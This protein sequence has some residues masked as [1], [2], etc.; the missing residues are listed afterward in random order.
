MPILAGSYQDRGCERLTQCS[1]RAKLFQFATDS[2]KWS[3]CGTGD[4]HLL[5]YKETKK[6][7]LVMRRD[8]TLKV[9]A[10]RLSKQTDHPDPPITGELTLVF[11]SSPTRASSLA[12]G[13]TGAGSGKFLRTIPRSPPPPTTL[14]LIWQT[15]RVGSSVSFVL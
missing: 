14:L 4:V 9:G 5:H 2:S 6:F 13:L 15:L 8:K 11:Q 1:R 10:N 3:E 7:R 12:L